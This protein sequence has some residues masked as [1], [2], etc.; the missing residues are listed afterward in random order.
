MTD[1]KSIAAMIAGVLTSQ[2]LQRLCDELDELQ[3][4]SKPFQQC[5][6]SGET[7]PRHSKKS[8]ENG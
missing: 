3:G 1:A 6:R 5:V 7:L 4:N 2:E 8:P